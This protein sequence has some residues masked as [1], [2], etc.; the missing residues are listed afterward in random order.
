MRNNLKNVAGV[1]HNAEMSRKR[2]SLLKKVLECVALLLVLVLILI[3]LTFGIIKFVDW[4][5]FGVPTQ[6]FAAFMVLMLCA[7]MGLAIGA[8]NDER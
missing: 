6:M 5:G 7:G 3:G 2:Q 1:R 4:L 8:D